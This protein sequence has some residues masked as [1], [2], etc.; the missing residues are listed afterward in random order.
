M[1]FF[2]RMVSDEKGNISHHRFVNVLIGVCSCVVV[3]WMS[4]LCKLT[5]EVFGLWLAYGAG[6]AGWSKFVEHKDKTV[7]LAPAPVAQ[8]PSLKPPKGK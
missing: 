3:V 6:L 5:S 7:E 1:D 4:Y 2:T 8:D